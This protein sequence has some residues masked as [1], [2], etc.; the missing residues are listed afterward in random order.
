MD[1]YKVIFD[2]KVVKQAGE[3]LVDRFCKNAKEKLPTKSTIIMLV[4]NDNITKEVMMKGSLIDIISE[5]AQLAIVQLEEVRRK[6]NKCTADAYYY[7]FVKAIEKFY[8]ERI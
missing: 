4:T 6:T 2:E 1:D 3:A 8:N 7:G 5:L